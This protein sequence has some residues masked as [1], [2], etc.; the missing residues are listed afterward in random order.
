MRS[1][2]QPR[3]HLNWFRARRMSLAH[4][5]TLLMAHAVCAQGCIIHRPA[6]LQDVPFQERAQSVEK[7]GVCVIPWGDIG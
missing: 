2:R 5:S 6:D 1:I 7:D 3:R 4:L